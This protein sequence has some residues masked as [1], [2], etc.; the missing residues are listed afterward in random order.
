MDF[1]YGK[2]ALGLPIDISLV[3]SESEI[4]SCFILYV[5]MAYS[6]ELK[7]IA[8]KTK[9]RGVLIVSEKPGDCLKG[10]GIN[11]IKKNNKLV[12]ELNQSA[13]KFSGLKVSEQLLSLAVVVK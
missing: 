7:A 5:P 4:S 2:S 8:E 10:A 9:N 13:I 12:F 6:N 1:T 11:I 3:K